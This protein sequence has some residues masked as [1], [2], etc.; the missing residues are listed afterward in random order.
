MAKKKRKSNRPQRVRSNRKEKYKNNTTNYFDNLM[1][2]LIN[3]WLKASQ[4]ALVYGE[5]RLKAN[6]DGSIKHIP[7]EKT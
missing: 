4:D 7:R 5:G 1:D 2:S 3:E 6:P